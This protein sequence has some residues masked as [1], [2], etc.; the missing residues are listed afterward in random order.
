MVHSLGRSSGFVIILATIALASVLLLVANIGHIT[1][2][3][4]EE[5]LGP[6]GNLIAARIAEILFVVWIVLFVY[7][8]IINFTRRR[9]ERKDIEGGGG[10][11]WGW[12][13][14]LLIII[15]FIVA[16]KL[17]SGDP[18]VVDEGGGGAGGGGEIIPGSGGEGGGSYVTVI[19]TIAIVTIIA[20]TLIWEIHKRR[21]PSRSI[22]EGEEVQAMVREAMGSLE[23]GNDP[24]KV[25]YDSYLRMCR[26][27]ERR[28]LSDI[29]YMTPGEFSTTAIREFHLPRDQVEELT[30]LFEEARYSEHIVGEDMKR[31]SISCLEGIRD[32]L[33]GR[34]V[35]I[36][37]S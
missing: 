11:S 30:S 37:S 34:G 18:G 7:F 31:R 14:A 13:L 8:M 33:E 2:Q 17:L 29:S 15:G 25:I 20:L 3:E 5:I 27:L 4:G 1:D 36:G 23:A 26:I 10:F 19:L 12:P 24:R 32:H 35:V 9:A 28:G 22:D 21:G 6:A 16:I